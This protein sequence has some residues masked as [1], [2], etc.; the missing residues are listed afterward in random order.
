MFAMDVSSLRSV[1]AARED[2]ESPLFQ[3]FDGREKDAL[4]I[5]KTNGIT[6]I[7]VRIWND[8]K[9][10][11][12][13]SYGGGNCDLNNAI[14][15]AKRAKV[16]GLGFIPDFHYS[17]FWADPSKQSI[18][19][20]WKS[21][22]EKQIASAVYQFTKES[23]EALDQTGVRIPMVQIGNETNWFL[24]G[25]YNWDSIA[26]YLS[27][28]SKA[29]RDVF[30]GMTK[31]NPKVALH[32]AGP[33]DAPYMDYAKELSKSKV[34]YD[35]FGSS[36]YPYYK[37]HGTLQNLSATLSSIHETYGKE[38]AIMETAYPW[39]TKDADGLGNHSID[40]TYMLHPISPQGMAS[41]LFDLTKTMV[42]LG[43]Y[44]LGISYW[45]GTWIASSSSTDAETNRALCAKHGSGWAT[46]FAASYDSEA[47]DGGTA[48]DNDAFWDSKT[49]KPIESLRAFN[50]MKLGYSRDGR[51]Q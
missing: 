16:V 20:A 45:E 7:R 42:N 30:A 48:V 49:G 17:D 36:Y 39:T 51:K 19:K 13:H 2:S 21:Y 1:E 33:G 3:D 43:D 31:N 15:L 44:A 8:P 26:S 24:L 11:K 37:S 46:R 23:L 28:G 35:V 4:Q 29:V 22:G 9:D 12:G 6:D 18:P 27:S 41:F 47:V 32:F 14:E 50:L 10:G 5:L 40:S 25:T 38:V 34:D